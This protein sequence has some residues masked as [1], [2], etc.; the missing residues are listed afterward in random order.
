[1]VFS[2]KRHNASFKKSGSVNF[3]EKTGT[4][5]WIK[6]MENKKIEFGT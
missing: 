2:E 5:A 3:E 1:L 4:E 6:W